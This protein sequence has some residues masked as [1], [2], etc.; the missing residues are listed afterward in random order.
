MT[1]TQIGEEILKLYNQVDAYIHITAQRIEAMRAGESGFVTI[2]IVSTGKYFAPHIIKAFMQA[3]P[4]IRLKPMIGNRKM[5][6]E[7][8]ENRSADFAIMALT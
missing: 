6:I 8:M 4:D 5:V 7:A 1:P 2:A 3:Y